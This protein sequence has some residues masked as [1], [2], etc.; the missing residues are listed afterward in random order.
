MWGIPDDFL[1]EVAVPVIDSLHLQQAPFFAT[2]MTVSNHAPYHI[3]DYF[4]SGQTD[5]KQKVIEYADWSLR[6]FIDMASQR[7][8][9]DNTLFIFLADHGAA[10]NPK[11]ELPL[12]YNHIPFIIYAPK[13]IPQARIFQCFGGQ[14]DMFPTIMHLLGLPYVNNTFGIDLLKEHRPF[15]Y[16]SAGNSWGVIND[17][18]FLLEP[19][20]GC[21]QLYRYR[22]GDLTN[23]V[24]QYQSLADEMKI[25]AQSNMQASQYIISRRKQS[26]D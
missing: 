17:T 13:I 20:Y 19:E 16:F 2:L 18:F 8:W 25:Y 15:I 14:I 21:E 26:C 4:T 10:I 24:E 6:K 7:P 23:Y 11:Y 5:D 9:F 3:P 1:F 22:E 12:S